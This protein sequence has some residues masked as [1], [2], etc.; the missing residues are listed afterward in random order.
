MEVLGSVTYAIE[1]EQDQCW[2][3]HAHQIKNLLPV[4]IS[5][6]ISEDVPDPNSE[7]EDVPEEPA[8]DPTD[9]VD[10]KLTVEETK[11]P[12]KDTSPPE[13]RVN[14]TSISKEES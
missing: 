4:A 9:S 1:T 8:V 14:R 2:K 13:T 10:L 11:A 5:G 12:P 6:D 7:P 3:W